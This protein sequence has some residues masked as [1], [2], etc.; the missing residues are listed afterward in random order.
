[1]PQLTVNGRPVEVA[2]DADAPLLYVLRNDLALKGSRFGCGEGVCGACT[3]LVDGVPATSCDL[4]VWAAAGHDITTIEALGDPS[5]PHPLQRAILEEQAAQCGF[6]RPGV[7]L[8]GAA[9]LAANPRPTRDQIRQALDAV[10]C[11]CG[12][13]DRMIRAVERAAASGVAA[14]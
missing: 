4:P 7:L 1:M 2:A 3:V 12:A 5:A 13:H 8:H 11:R 14:S 9:L 6:C 10:L